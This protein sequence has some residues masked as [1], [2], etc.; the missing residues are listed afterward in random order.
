[1][2]TTKNSMSVGELVGKVLCEGNA[3]FLQG[4]I[5]AFLK[6]V[7]VAE[8]SKLTGA[9]PHE[10]SEDR[11]NQRNGYRDRPY[12]TRVGTLALA[13]PKLRTGSYMPSFLEPR[14][15][16]EEALLNVIQEAYVHGVSTRKVEALVQAM[17]VDGVSK[18][19]VS[20][21]CQALD[22]QVEAFRNRPLTKAYPYLWLDAKY[23]KV[24][25]NGRVVTN[26]LVVAYG[27]NEEGH[28]EIIGMDAGG[29]ECEAFWTEF[30]R[31]LV[32]RGLTGVKLVISDAHTGLKASIATVMTGASWQRCIVHFMRNVMGKVAKHSQGMVIAAVKTIF[33]QPTRAAA[34]D[35][36]V[37]MAD[38]LRQ[39]H[40]VVAEMLI[41]AQEDILAHM[42]F[43]GDHWKKIRS[44]N[45]LERLNKEIGRRADVVG[46]FPNRASIVRLI[47]MVL[48]EQNDEWQVGKRY[49]S[50]ESLS[51]MGPLAVLPGGGMAL[52]E[53]MTAVPSLA[54]VA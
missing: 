29:S 35:Q 47:G 31:G 16:S 33:T 51:Q 36:L 49:M 12:D 17:G 4:A 38:M 40:P 28:R 2:T 20:R 42:A 9:Q 44:T 41:E 1:M 14:R 43:P 10:R 18:S 8:I 5:L 30:L 50:L 3:D 13:V 15:R 39:K 53:M 46:I 52:P 32:A 24:R 11:I 34:N 25:E 7:M 37:K 6:E 27:V 45:P 26:A 21:I 23:I 22:E 54:Q 19:E 48:A